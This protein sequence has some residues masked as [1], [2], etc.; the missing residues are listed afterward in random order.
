MRMKEEHG[1][2]LALTVV[3]NCAISLVVSITAYHVAV[4]YSAA[5]ALSC[6]QELRGAE[7]ARELEPQPA[8]GGP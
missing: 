5:F 7:L 2:H 1:S 4:K 8:A 3:T 6:V